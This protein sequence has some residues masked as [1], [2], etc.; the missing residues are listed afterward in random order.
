MALAALVGLFAVERSAPQDDAS[1]Y[2]VIAGRLAR[3]R[4]PLFIAAVDHKGPLWAMVY[5]LAW[6]VSGHQQWFWFVIAALF[7][8][9]AGAIGWSVFRIAERLTGARTPSLVAAWTVTGLIV[10]GPDSYSL[11]LYGRNI[12]AA[13]TAVAAVVVF[14]RIAP[15]SDVRLS[16]L[17]DGWAGVLLGGALLGLATQTVLTSAAP[18]VALAIG[19]AVTGPSR[20]RSVVQ[21]IAVLV[22]ATGVV[23]IAPLWYSLRG[24]GGAFSLYWWDYNQAYA[25]ANPAPIRGRIA[26]A[27]LELGLWVVTGIYPLIALAAFGVLGW[28]ARKSLRS[29]TPLL[30]VTMW[31]AAEL[32]SV[33]AP[34]RWFDHYWIL[35]LAPTAILG[36]MLW[37]HFSAA[38]QPKEPTAA[39]VAPAPLPIRLARSFDRLSVR[40]KLTI[41]PLIGIALLC[42][43]SVLSGLSLLATYRGPAAHH[44]DRD[45]EAPG[46]IATLRGIVEITVP[47]HD[48]IFSWSPAADTYTSLDRPAATRFDR[49]QWLTGEV[50]GGDNLVILPNAWS[51]AVADLEQSQPK[52]IVE[53]LDV[54]IDGDSP[55]ATFI[56]AN[57]VVAFESQAELP[58]RVYARLGQPLLKAAP[59]T[60]VRCWFAP[61][62]TEGSIRLAGSGETGRFVVTPNLVSSH[63]GPGDDPADS[64]RDAHVER[65]GA[66]AAS[67]VVGPDAAVLW[68]ADDTI[69][70]A[71]HVPHGI[72]HVLLETGA[73]ALQSVPC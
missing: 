53:T 17:L 2:W 25:S 9:F 60:D 65:S 15:P 64:G 14:R 31:W 48:T 32:V 36:A 61:E 68:G 24:A 20:R 54:P 58:V 21:A 33:I 73:E 47:E 67:L 8:V 12:T 37:V 29:S 22:V 55:L 42:V 44:A 59:G 6:A 63:R 7:L 19:I 18:T 72:D 70:A 50:L 23:L 27:A 49:R 5:R 57:Y 3:E 46:A 35:M 62:L 13:L 30:V 45:A 69:L 66:A 52:L 71:M 11:S 51:E 1:Q 26:D 43:P 41:V 10:F 38:D 40:R 56:R 28:A 4:E 39:A 16:R 34:N